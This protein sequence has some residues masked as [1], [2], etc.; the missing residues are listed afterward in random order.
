MRTPNR[1]LVFVALIV[2]FTVAYPAAAQPVDDGGF[3]VALTYGRN[4]DRVLFHEPFAE[5]LRIAGIRDLRVDRLP[6]TQ[7]IVGVTAGNSVGKH[8][9]VYS[10]F[11]YNDLGNTH[12]SGRVPFANRA[13]F[14]TQVKFFEWTS[15]A[16][17][18]LPTG[19][20]R[21]RPYVGSGVGTLWAQFTGDAEGI[22]GESLTATDF[23]YH[24]EV[25]VRLFVT[26]RFG[27]APE[28]RIVGIPDETFYRGLVNLIFRFR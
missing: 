16:R 28:L 9:L 23:L 7:Q 5:G 19:T 22:A 27:V 13:T 18:Q 25:G 17:L 2:L 14:R 21:V 3:E 20:W 26:R 1:Y 11:A 12:V 6:D 4:R 10:E 15:G 24:G 8:V